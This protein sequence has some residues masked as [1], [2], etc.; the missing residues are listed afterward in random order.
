[1]SAAA[2]LN[3]PIY[4]YG[5]SFDKD[6]YPVKDFMVDILIAAHRQ[7]D[8][9]HLS[10]WTY[11][12]TIHGVMFQIDAKQFHPRATTRLDHNDLKFFAGLKNVRYVDFSN[13]QIV[14]ALTHYEDEVPK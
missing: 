7:L 3:M 9:P 12:A 2:E 14:I 6:H 5:D 4:D 10:Q 1:M 8:L 13:D 11:F